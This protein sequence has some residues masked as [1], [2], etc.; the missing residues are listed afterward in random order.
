MK[1]A[2]LIFSPVLPAIQVF[3]PQSKE[4]THFQITPSYGIEYQ[5]TI[6]FHS[7]AGLGHRGK[8]QDV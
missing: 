5:K 4:S 3:F 7:A 2:M 8:R 6:T 1:K